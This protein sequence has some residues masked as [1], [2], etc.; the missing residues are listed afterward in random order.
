MGLIGD[1]DPTLDK[2]LG[3]VRGTTTANLKLQAM[4]MEAADDVKE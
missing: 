1:P 4:R 2:P 3:I